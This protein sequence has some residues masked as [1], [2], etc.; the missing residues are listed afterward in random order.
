MLTKSILS[1]AVAVALAA[2]LGITGWSLWTRPT[3]MQLPGI[4]EMHE[5][6]LAS[7][8]GGRVAEV[9]VNEGDRVKPGQP[10]LRLQA[11]ELAA[12]S[13]QQNARL[14]A[15]KMRL[16]LARRGPT[17]EA[18]AAARAAVDAAA[19]RLKRVQAGPRA[20]TIAEAKAELK[21]VE[22][23]LTEKQAAL[24]RLEPL[25][26]R[27]AASQQ[28]LE[29]ARSEFQQASALRAKA[30]SRLEML[31]SGAREEE[32]AEAAAQL[33]QAQAQYDDLA[34]GTR[35]EEVAIAHAAVAELKAEI[36]Q[37]QIQREETVIRAASHS[38]VE[39]LAVRAGDILAPSQPAVR[40]L[41]AR[42]VWV[43]IY[44]P[45]TQLGKLKTGQRVFV[46]VDSHPRQRFRGHVSHI[47]S[48]AEFTPRNVQTLQARRHQLFAV[49]I[50]IADDE[51]VFKSG[52]AACVQLPPHS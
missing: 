25:S 29:R 16:A 39:S 7:K 44:L 5:V 14:E 45:E 20:E 41:S 21:L 27:G 36:Q 11:P 17:A 9:L 19:A 30:A 37:L 8:L 43:K 40:I 15:A 38:V 26:R 49:K 50:R 3:A 48:T 34:A 4:V 6:G 24:R 22:A 33:A 23:S 2:A 32:I 12:R 47:A 42:D 18:L 28:E 31:Q 46:S 1:L 13:A 10:L 51:G 35:E 52:M